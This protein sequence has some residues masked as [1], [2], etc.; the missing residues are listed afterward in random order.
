MVGIHRLGRIGKTTIA[1]AIYNRI[2]EH[3]EESCFLENVREN[4]GTNDGIIQL[5][6]KLLSNI[7]RGKH[8]KV[9]SVAV[10]SI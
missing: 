6:E 2:F 7:L 10:E 1:K 3:F 9:E 5:Q 8:L 4:Y